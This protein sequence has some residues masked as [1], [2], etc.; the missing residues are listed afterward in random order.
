MANSCS[1]C[2]G[3][4]SGD[5]DAIVQDADLSWWDIQKVLF[6]ASSAGSALTNN[7][8]AIKIVFEMLNIKM[9][10]LRLYIKSIIPRTRH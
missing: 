4:F 10:Q 8:E 3:I 1:W 9:E 7:L 5:P 6:Q 2:S